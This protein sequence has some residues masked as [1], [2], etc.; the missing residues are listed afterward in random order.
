MQFEKN[1]SSGVAVVA[2]ASASKGCIKECTCHLLQTGDSYK[3]K[4]KYERNKI[5]NKCTCAITKSKCNQEWNL[6]E[7]QVYPQAKLAKDVMSVCTSH[8]S[9]RGRQIQIQMQIQV[10]VYPQQACKGCIERPLH[11]CASQGET[12]TCTHSRAHICARN[13]K[14]SSIPNTNHYK[15]SSRHFNSNASRQG[16][17][18]I[19]NIHYTVFV[20]GIVTAQQMFHVNTQ[21]SHLKSHSTQ[22]QANFNFLLMSF[23]NFMPLKA[24]QVDFLCLFLA[25]K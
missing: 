19:T 13:T 21:N 11:R 15:R 17:M 2:L 10:Q 6:Q 1:E 14:I 20:S 16:Q 4:Y 22:H 3:Y 8:L 18:V 23:P 12:A 5:A 7:E 9:H 25:F 24:M